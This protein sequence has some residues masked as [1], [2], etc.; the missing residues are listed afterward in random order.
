M[1]FR[2]IEEKWQRRWRDAGVF[3]TPDEPG[4]DKFYLLEMFAYP[5]G[6]VHMG[7]F[8]NYSIGDVVW[9]YKRMNGK[10]ILHPFGW[11][12]F[13]LPAEQAAIKRNIHPGEW[14]EGNIATGKSTLQAMGLS[15]DWNREVATSRPDFYKWTQWVF[16]Q[17]YKKGLAYQKEAVVNWC[18]K[19]N[20]VL[21]N[22]QVVGGCCWRHSDTPVQRKVL[23]Q[24]FFRI[25]DYA[26]RLLD[27]LGKL[28]QWPNTVKTIQRHWIGRSEGTNIRFTVVETGDELP[29]FTTRP[30]T[31]FGVTFMAIAPEAELMHNLIERCP[32]RSAVEEYIHKAEMKSEIER[33]AE[34]REKDGVDTG[35]HVRNPYNGDE[36]PLFV[37]D[38][39]LAG[40]GSGAVMAVPA[41]DRR[42]FAFAK[43]YKIPIKAV[44]APPEGAISP[45][46]MT[47]AYTE[48]GIMMN[49]AH[50]DGMD[51]QKAIAAI[52][53][54]G[55]EKGFAEKTIQFKL[56]DWLISRQRYWG[57]PIPVVHCEKCGVVP[58]PEEDLPVELPYVDDFLPRGRSPLADVPEFMNTK[59]PVCG[60]PATRD[61]DT[62]DTFVCSSWYEL[63]YTDPHNDREPFD[64]EAAKKWLPVDL[65]IGGIEHATGHLLYFRFIAKVLHDLGWLSVDE[66]VVKLF[67]HGMVCD[68][69]GDIMSKS[70]GNVVSPIVVMKRYGVDVSRIA[71]LFFAPPDREISWN[72]SGIKGAE[73]FLKR[74]DRLIIPN[75]DPSR[76]ADSI[77]GLSSRD[78]MLYRELHRTV[79]V[80]TDDLE[81]MSFNTA[82]ARL[83]EFINVVSPEDMERSAIAF[84]IADTLAR[85]LAPFAPHLAEELNERLGHD[86]LIVERPWPVCDESVIGF[87][88]VEIGVQVGG[89]LRGTIRL[90]P[91]ADRESAVD[92]A[93]KISNIRKNI[94]GKTIIKIIYVPGRILNIIVE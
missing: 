73:R 21:A 20:T 10:K 74:I 69:N 34:D 30:D 40:Y 89:R 11:D 61:P 25:T 51:S 84:T 53:D 83:M 49:S 70:K 94:E 47:D 76:S 35:F 46:E 13:G 33:V 9:R 22:E 91:D 36:V 86:C 67:N 65:Y 45:E 55:V 23:K 82:I 18:P 88:T 52:T 41:H 93:M 75:I 87:D 26:Q 80:V 60:G 72:E 2:E 8:R 24:W 78:A 44:I 56:R 29:I 32:N 39:V 14:T 68:E 19:C 42:D 81:K 1:S 4:E 48:P 85:L 3:D 7:H 90:S 79:G 43:R 12:S 71:M 37:A 62:M 38:Y 92:E 64:R 58:V 77:D 57:A 66:P 6:D 5:S 63:R 28:E 50:F 59:C 54:F 17:L 31:V 27:D 16:L 15:Y